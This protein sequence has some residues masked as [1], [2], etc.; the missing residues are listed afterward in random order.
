[1]MKSLLATMMVLGV[2]TQ[3]Q[4]AF[5][6]ASP[7]DVCN[8]YF[9]DA[10]KRAMEG[11]EPVAE[12]EAKAVAHV[13]NIVLGMNLSAEKGEKLAQFYLGVIRLNPSKVHEIGKTVY[14]I[15]TT[16]LSDDS[17]ANMSKTIRKI[18]GL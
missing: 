12:D 6:A 2:F 16:D 11:K 5:A 3:A 13:Q 15:C 17:K 8:Q 1:M 10:S 9:N 14:F 7:N 4:A 18:A